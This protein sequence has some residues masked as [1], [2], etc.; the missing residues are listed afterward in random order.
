MAGLA[1]AGPA[2]GYNVT[3]ASKATVAG[4]AG[5][6]V[7]ADYVG[8]TTPRLACAIDST[9]GCTG[10]ATD[11]V[12][13]RAT[14][15]AASA[16]ST[17]SNCPDAR[18]AYGGDTGNFCVLPNT[19]ADKK[20]YA[21]FKPI[22][23][24]LVV[25]PGAGGTVTAAGF[26]TCAASSTCTYV[27]PAGATVALTATPDAGKL[28]SAWAGCTSSTAS[29]SVLV[30][31]GKVVSATFFSGTEYGVAVGVNGSGSVTG[32]GIACPGDCTTRLAAGG[33]LTLTAT[34]ATGQTFQAWYGCSSTSGT[35]CEL[36]DV[37][38]NRSVTASFSTS[39]CGSCHGKPPAAPH[40]ART[41]C[42]ACHAGYT[43][44][45]AN[46]AL[47]LNG[48][49]DLDHAGVMTE[50]FTT[51]PQVTA[52]CLG[53]HPNQ[54]D[55]VLGSVHFTWL[56]SSAMT[57]G[58]L[59]QTNIGKR[60]LVNNFCVAVPSNEARC[61]QCHPSYS[62][63]PTKDAQGAVQPNT[64]PMYLWASNPA[65]DKTKIDCLICHANLT[66]SQY[67]KAAAPFGAPTV[68]NSGAACFP[69]CTAAQSCINGT[70]VVPTADQ[71]TTALTAAART[72]SR[73][74]RKNCGFCHFI[75]GGGDD[76]KMGD[77]GSAL[78]ASACDTSTPGGVCVDV[79][80]GKHQKVC[81]DCHAA[82]NHRLKGAGLSIPIDNEG[83]T[84]CDACHASHRHANAKYD[85]HSAF[86]ACQTC[87]IPKFSQTQY[88][89]VNWDWRTAIDKTAC[90][91]LTGCVSFNPAT[92]RGGEADKAQNHVVDPLDPSRQ[93]ALGYD[94][95]KGIST[96]EKNV[97]P[98]YRWFDGTGTHAATDNS[99]FASEPNVLSKPNGAP[100][101]NGSRIHPFKK[102]TG[103]SP[104]LADDSAMLVPHVFGTDSLWQANL[105]NQAVAPAL[106]PDG[107]TSW[108]WSAARADAIWAGVL[109]Y[110]A[111]VGGQLG[112]A[113]AKAA[114]GGMVRDASN[115]VTVTTLAPVAFSAGKRLFLVGAQA[116]FPT[117]VKTVTSVAADNLSFTYSETGTAGSS[118][119][120]VSFFD[121]LPAW[122]WVQTEMY[123]NLN[124]EVQPKAK[125]LTCAGC[126]PTMGG[127]AATS[128]MKELYDLGG[129]CDDPVNCLKLAH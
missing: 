51:G 128:R 35:T 41:D 8:T 31:G 75:A 98:V 60:N 78:A 108:V 124:H 9:T 39:T 109:N 55:D 18:A 42:G 12:V 69:S 114:T 19:A 71:K 120:P 67:A 24:T 119:A 26:G 104:G 17:W 122:K 77:L 80:M 23:F 91:G 95:K 111:A 65:V 86:I 62:A 90:Q 101:V 116:Q 29:C 93:L 66:T 30:N 34:P 113:R 82:P 72:V 25:K 121:E 20:V 74:D 103:R 110:G 44:A 45:Y 37:A 125:A 11:V 46:P 7:D 47:H 22:A 40:V 79:H 89:K 53:C 70:C 115:V 85:S 87:H 100:G 14:P 2:L 50:T 58:A 15:G 38:S 83:R 52:K 129:T 33:S 10:T 59:P 102:M 117:G 32:A 21:Y 63:A 49:V 126:H 27:V 13:L 94:W 73:P 99:D 16:F 92:Q 105:A 57:G 3:V 56:G 68:G 97:T 1:A 127:S 106:E 84:D 107:V 54:A 5:T 64:G 96:Y 61:L 48:K 76:V 28:F 112:P 4:A 43:L 88:T 6:I 81:A 123:I 36:T 118:G